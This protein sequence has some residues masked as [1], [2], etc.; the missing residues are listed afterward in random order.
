MFFRRWRMP[1][2]AV[3]ASLVALP[4]SR[5]RGNR[6]L[7]RLLFPDCSTSSLQKYQMFRKYVDIYSSERYP[8]TLDSNMF[9]LIVDTRTVLASV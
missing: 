8:K 2:A 4:P 3:T 1:L 5:T 9:I 7:P 6:W